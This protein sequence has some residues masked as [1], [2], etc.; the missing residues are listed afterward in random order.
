MSRWCDGDDGPSDTAVSH[1]PAGTDPGAD[2]MDEARIILI[3]LAYNSVQSREG[4]HYRGC[5]LKEPPW[6]SGGTRISR[7]SDGID[8]I[9][10][11]T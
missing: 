11:S 10:S 3:Y 1:G 8:S 6:S 4:E 5:S 9:I 2:E 7:D